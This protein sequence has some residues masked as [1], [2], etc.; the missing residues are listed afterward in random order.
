[1]EAPLTLSLSLS[2]LFVRLPSL[3]S[4]EASRPSMRVARKSTYP[5]LIKLR[6]ILDRYTRPTP[7]TAIISPQKTGRLSLEDS[8]DRSVPNVRI[9]LWTSSLL[10]GSGGQVIKCV[11]QE[12]N[13]YLTAKGGIVRVGRTRRTT[14]RERVSFHPILF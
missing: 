3:L 10:G 11:S 12:N 1:M 5:R 6:Q 7:V 4:Y 8:V 13:G 2:P 14:V 9:F